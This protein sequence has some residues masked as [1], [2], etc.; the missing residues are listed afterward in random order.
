MKMNIDTII[1]EGIVSIREW[2]PG[3][4]V[5]QTE[6]GWDDLKERVRNGEL[7]NGFNAF[8]PEYIKELANMSHEEILKR[9]WGEKWQEHEWG[10]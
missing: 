8:V 1:S 9:V 4:Y 7:D 3:V 10:K 6:K 5:V 2:E